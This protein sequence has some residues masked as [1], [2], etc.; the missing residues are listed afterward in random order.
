MS[1]VNTPAEQRIV[2][3]DVSWETYLALTSESDRPGKRIAFDQGVM[4]IMSPGI[5]HENAGRLIGR[6]VEVF[7][8]EL[9]IEAASVKSTTSAGV[10]SNVGSRRMRVFISQTRD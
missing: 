7:T 2:L 3:N 9:N 6:M 1:I 4:E 10:T 8:L 5:L